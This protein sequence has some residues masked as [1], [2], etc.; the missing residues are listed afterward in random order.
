MKK[1]L[2]I[3]ILLLVSM[4]SYSFDDVDE[5]IVEDDPYIGVQIAL[6]KYQPMVYLSNITDKLTPSKYSQN[7][8]RLITTVAQSKSAGVD[9][10][11]D[12]TKKLTYLPKNTIFTVK[13]ILKTAVY[14]DNQPDEYTTYVLEDSEGKNYAM[15]DFELKDLSRVKLSSYELGLIDK[16]NEQSNLAR[17]VVY[18]SKP[19]LYKDK[20]APYSEKDL[21]SVFDFFLDKIK[22]YKTDK[23]LLSERNFR[24]SMT[25]PID[26]LVYM[27][28]EFDSL[29][30]EDIEV[31][32]IPEKNNQENDYSKGKIRFKESPLKQ[33]Y[34]K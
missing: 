22:N 6:E 23:V 18:F 9:L 2:I 12:N 15:P 20:K 10:F 11:I 24:L 7:I 26:T 17:V 3:V 25:I 14:K 5:I 16:F 29:Y 4:S 13:R 30:I 21:A 19:P 8:D 28:S 27:I 32:S 34:S 1:K 31:I 33:W